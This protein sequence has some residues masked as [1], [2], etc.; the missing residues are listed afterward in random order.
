MPALVKPSS[1]RTKFCQSMQNGEKVEIRLFVCLYL[2]ILSD[3]R[4]DQAPIPLRRD[5][6]AA[7]AT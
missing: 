1:K 3:V 7:L 2:R 4:V 5:K 6:A